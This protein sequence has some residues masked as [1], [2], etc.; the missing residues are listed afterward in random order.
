MAGEGWTFDLLSFLLGLFVAGFLGSIFNRIML[1]RGQTK[2]PYQKMA[3]YTDQTPDDVFQAARG[4]FWR[5]LGW[6]II[7]GISLFILGSLIYYLSI[8]EQMFY[9]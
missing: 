2:R 8:Q 9:F 4:A 3:V 1:E 6:Y 7:L 5:L